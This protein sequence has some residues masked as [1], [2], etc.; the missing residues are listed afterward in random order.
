MNDGM[1]RRLAESRAMSEKLGD[2]VAHP[3]N[4]LA[5]G[6][7]EEVRSERELT[8]SITIN[9]WTDADGHESVEI[10]SSHDIS[11]LAVKGILHDGIFAIAH[12]PVEAPTR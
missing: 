2:E 7:P 9:V 12:L 8:C 3:F 6:S 5:D 11:P 4:I 10:E 1:P